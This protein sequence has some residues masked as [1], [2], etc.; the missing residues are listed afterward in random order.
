V[1]VEPGG[2]VEALLRTYPRVRPE[3]PPAH[4]ATYVEHYRAN[5]AGKSG[6]GRIAMRLESW[7]HRR[8]AEDC[9]AER[10]LEIG[11]GSLN[12]VPYHPRA[13]V[14]DAVEPFRELWEDSPNRARIGRMY[15]DLAEVPV[16]RRYDAIVSVAVLEHLTDLPSILA[17]S[18]LLLGENGEFRA[19]FPSEGGLLWGLAWR[20]TTGLQYRWE[21]GL[22]YSA[23]M[24]HEH[25]N[26]ADEI[27]TLLAHFYERIALI[28][29]PAPWRHFSFYTVAI[30]RSPHIA[31]C[32]E[33]L[34]KGDDCA[35][36][37]RTTEHRHPGL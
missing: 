12:H 26:T 10:V 32:R 34:R 22:D 6:I 24:R 23:I 15:G 18:A 36:D 9:H 7:M 28:R 25:V 27:V 31:R 37:A 5:R 33:L 13:R 21:R 35:D 11:A 8:V 1:S 2:R 30:A 4:R 29:F 3:L 20:T 17:R 19:G 16:E 14:Y